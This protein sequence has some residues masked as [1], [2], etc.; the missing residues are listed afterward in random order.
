MLQAL[1]DSDIATLKSINFYSNPDW[2]VGE[3]AEETTGV[4]L[5][6]QVISK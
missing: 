2:F 3:E 4:D 1:A 5:L 6:M